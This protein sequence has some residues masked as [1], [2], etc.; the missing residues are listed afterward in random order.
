MPIPNALLLITPGC[1]HC[2]AVLEGLTTLVKEGTLGALEVVNI[3]VH[4]ERAAE[5]GVRSVP[6]CRI[7]PIELTGTQSP[8]E[9]RRWAEAATSDEGIAGWL[10]E[11]LATG[12]LA[13][14]EAKVKENPALLIPLVALLEDPETPMQTRVGIGAIFESLHG[15]GLAAVATEALC[16]LAA[17][18]DARVRADAC[19]YL[20]F[21]ETSDA[22][23]CLQAR[24]DDD[25]PEVR[26]IARESLDLL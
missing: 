14:A 7:G 19:H 15:T 25:D 12:G 23:P 24:L 18:P 9:L 22:R 5:L 1:P 26:E 16:R 11:R 17:H 21:T 4:S 2:P 8:A 20:G 6:W 10:G 13:L 3:A